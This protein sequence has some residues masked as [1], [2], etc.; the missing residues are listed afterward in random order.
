MK[1]N[2][3]PCKAC[4]KKYADGNC[5]IN[6]INNCVVDTATAF[7][8]FPSNNV[9]RGNAAGENWYECMEERM[10]ALPYQ[11]G[12][13]RNFL[14]LQLNMAPAWNQVP[15]YFPSLLEKTQDPHKARDMC[16]LQCNGHRLSESCKET[17][18]TD[19]DAVE[20][21][22]NYHNEQDSSVKGSM[23]GKG[24]KRKGRKRKGRKKGSSC[25][26]VGTIIVIAIVII[27]VVGVNAMKKE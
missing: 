20:I 21:K 18:Q 7:S 12:E 5:N 1:Y 16:K 14:N 23:K 27:I 26:L 15:H 24:R 8:A 11:A 17:C 3:N 2:I 4:R 19:F 10:A 25:S 22:E 9:M 6:D 13:P